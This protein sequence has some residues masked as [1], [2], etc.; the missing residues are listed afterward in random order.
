M[1]LAD[2]RDL[3]LSGRHWLTPNWALTYDLLSQEHAYLN[4]RQG[5]RLG[6][7]RSF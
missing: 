4:R 6:V 2:V 5:L 7:S 1:Q 3:T